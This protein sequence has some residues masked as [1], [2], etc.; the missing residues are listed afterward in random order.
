[1][2]TIVITQTLDFVPFLRLSYYRYFARPI[3]LMLYA[4]VVVIIGLFIFEGSLKNGFGP[5]LF[6]VFVFV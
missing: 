5:V 6:L 3:I 4:L 1:M 2:D